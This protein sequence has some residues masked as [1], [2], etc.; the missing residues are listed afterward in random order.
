MNI[1]FLI[2][3]GFDL[4]LGLQ[5]SYK[6]FYEYYRSLPGDREDMIASSIRSDYALWADLELGL[7]RFL[8]QL[9]PEQVSDFLD[10]KERLE[11]AL[12]D[13][14]HQEEARL[15]IKN[16][17]RLAA[18]FQ[19]N[20]V[21]FC[22]E[23][24][25]EERDLYKKAITETSQ[26]IHY[27]FVNFNYTGTLDAL[28]QNFRTKINT[29][30]SHI[31]RSGEYN[32]VLDPPFHIHGDLSKKDMILGVD[33]IEQIQNKDLQQNAEL[34]DCMVKSN[35]N[36]AMGQRR[37]EKFKRIIDDSLYVCMY[38]L[39]I[40]ETDQTWWQYLVEWL[41][42]KST[43]R[44]VIYYY[45]ARSPQSAGQ[46]SRYWSKIKR[47]FRKNSKCSEEQ[48]E[49]IKSQIIIL[50]NSP[51]FNFASLGVAPREAEREAPVMSFEEYLAN[52]RK[53][54]AGVDP[55]LLS[56]PAVYYTDGLVSPTLTPGSIPTDEKIQAMSYDELMKL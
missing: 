25:E 19:K 17:A 23:F 11:N 33:S 39:S 9:S 48:F 27:S 41:S 29:F 43:H 13:Y 15:Q 21:G 4:N 53:L 32:D 22:E 49:K 28:I 37:V 55:E 26:S 56:R 7:G 50:V 16:E 47:L 34:V 2:G 6:Q 35:L 44:L 1:T 8:E 45:D 31:A 12:I 30:S 51:I 3:N 38:G 20:V 24:G 5:T 52:E 18:E 42:R 10:S 46:K 14:L 54:L 36:Q 40:G